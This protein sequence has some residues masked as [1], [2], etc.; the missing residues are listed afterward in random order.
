MIEIAAALM[1]GAS[2]TEVP[3]ES[4][5][6]RNQIEVWCAADGCAATPAEEST[7]M[8]F[9][10]S[11]DGSLSACAYSGCWEGRA[12]VSASAGRLLWIGDNLPFASS[13]EGA[14]GDVTLLILAKDGV[15]F[16]RAGGI[17]TPVLC[18]RALKA[19]D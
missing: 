10:A 5:N 2:R 4:W 1:L 14:A 16:I 3:P 7:P 12:T 19:A 13:V 17:A 8:D 18:R 9:W 6:C 15:G 11:A